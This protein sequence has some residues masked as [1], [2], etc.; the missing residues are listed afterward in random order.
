MNGC[1]SNIKP[2]VSKYAIMQLKIGFSLFVSGTTAF[3]HITTEALRGKTHRSKS[4]K[5]PTIMHLILIYVIHNFFYLQKN[6]T[7]NL[8]FFIKNRCVSVCNKIWGVVEFLK[9]NC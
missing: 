1:S 3:S 5:P 7:W 2:R 6:F 8:R 4:E 9:L